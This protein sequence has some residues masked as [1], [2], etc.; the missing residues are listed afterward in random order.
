MPSPKE[1]SLPE[2]N[3]IRDQDLRLF[4]PQWRRGNRQGSS[5]RYL[6]ADQSVAVS[7]RTDVLNDC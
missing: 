5:P 6:H 7:V 1:E 3:P 4:V 2:D